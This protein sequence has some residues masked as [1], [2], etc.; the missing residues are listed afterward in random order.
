MKTSATSFNKKMWWLIGVTLVVKIF[1]SFFLELGNDEVYYYTYAVQPDWNHFDHPGMVGWMM[2][3]TSLN[4]HWVSALSM[5][6]GSII[7]AG[8]ATLVI[9]KTGTIIKDEKAGYIAAW[10]YTLS[11]YTS[12]IA[13]LFVLPDSPQLLFF[14]LSIYWMTK[15]VMQPLSFTTKHWLLLGLLIGLATLSKVHGLYLWIGF[16]AFILF[17]QIKTLKN[18]RVYAAILVTLLCIVPIVYWNFKNDFITYR[19]HS[20]RVMHTGLLLDSFL[21]QIVGE[22]IYQN[23]LVYLAAF[24]A[25]LNIKKIKL[26]LSASNQNQTI[27]LLLWLSLPLIFTFWAISLFNPTLPHWTGPGFIGLFIIAGVYWSQR[28]E[29]T[30]AAKN[31]SIPLV[32]KGALGLLGASILGFLLLVYIFPRQ[33]GS[34]KMENL[35]EYNPIN[36]VTGWESFTESFAKIVAMDSKSGLMQKRD[37]II[38]HKWFPAGHILFYTARPLNKR[39]IAIG[40]LEDVHKFAWLNKT[41]LNNTKDALKIGE[42]AYC[43]VPSNLPADPHNLYGNYFETISKPDTIPMISKG[44]LLRNFYVYRLIHCKQIPVDIIKN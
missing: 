42:N 26:Q 3:F 9:F 2:R 23:P 36:D 39:V 25:L 7:C 22:I 34:T 4:L 31:K 35:G 30:Y 10:M 28:L 44:V 29:D 13:G 20:Q 6:L 27:N 37:P 24:I 5:R 43:I 8:V 40:S 19:Y 14:T 18:G 33:L 17:H 21:Q 38:I 16:G 12:I 41:Q 32:L 1:L 11:I 15:W